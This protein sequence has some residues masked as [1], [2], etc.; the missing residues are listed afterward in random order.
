VLLRVND[1]SP[2]FAFYLDSYRPGSIT[3]LADPPTPGDLEATRAYSL[4]L[5]P[6]DVSP[7]KA[8]LDVLVFK[9]DQ[10]VVRRFPSAGGADL[11][12]VL[13]GVLKP[14]VIGN[15]YVFDG[16]RLAEALEPLVEPV[17]P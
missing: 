5:M 11:A 3:E 17:A 12:V 4:L 2:N 7:E 14:D 16:G 8:A 13:A 15:L 6:S 10:L 9:P 1:L